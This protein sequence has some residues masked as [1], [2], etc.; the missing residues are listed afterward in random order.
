MV[1][2]VAKM[3]TKSTVWDGSVYSDSVDEVMLSLTYLTFQMV[4]EGI[5][6]F[7]AVWCTNVQAMTRT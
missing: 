5:A 2:I 7:A 3:F 6:V 4:C 1:V